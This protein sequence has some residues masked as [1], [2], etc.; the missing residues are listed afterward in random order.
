MAKP[1]PS[2]LQALAAIRRA[3]GEAGLRAFL[4][5][6]RAHK[7]EALLKALAPKKPAAPTVAAVTA[8]LAPF[9][10][11]SAEKA[12]MLAAHLEK[13]VG[14]SL[15]VKARGLPDAVRA[16]GAYLSEDDIRDGAFSLRV[17]LQGAQTPSRQ[18][19]K[20]PPHG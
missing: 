15:P 2:T 10:E 18:F 3:D 20:D 7:D 13:L 1:R 11:K 19:K 4:A 6:I 17:V 12:R 16:L 5:D 14:R 8:L 9:P